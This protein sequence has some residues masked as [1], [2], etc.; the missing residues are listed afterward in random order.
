MMINMNRQPTPGAALSG[1]ALSGAALSGAALSGQALSGPG[2]RPARL[3][4]WLA[5]TIEEDV[6]A[7]GYPDDA[8][9]PTETVLAQTYGVSRQVVREAARLLED[10]G[11]VSI[12]AGRGMT[13]A[14]AGVDNIVLRYRT[15]LRRDRAGF[16]HLMQLR[17]MS[18]VEMTAL[19]ATS[20]TDADIERLW[21]ILDTAI[22]HRGDYTAWLDADLAFHVAVARATQNPFVMTFIQP[23][24]RVLRDVYREPIGYLATQDNTLQE[25]REIA[26][27]ISDGDP[28][29]ARK[30]AS[31]HLTRVIN[32][33]EKLIGSGK[34]GPSGKPSGTSD[35]PS[36]A[37]KPSPSDERNTSEQASPGD[38]PL[39]H[40][41][42]RS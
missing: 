19:A 36:P 7:Q 38:A 16:E 37:G 29:A 9:L 5:D 18:E 20:R 11:L 41:T 22:E 6:L 21:Q 25:H 3:P 12:R 31:D 14:A 23:I 27:A 34:P 4:Q 35:E 1:A 2:A 26:R 13:V 28:V 24:N 42:S 8:Q 33:A 39:P 15:L 17:Q 40:A 10:R 30:A 32:D